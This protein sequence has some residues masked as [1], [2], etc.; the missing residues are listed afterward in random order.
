MKWTFEEARV[1]LAVIILSDRQD[2]WYLIKHWNYWTVKWVNLD[3][4]GRGWMV[5]IR[6]HEIWIPYD[7]KIKTGGHK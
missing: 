5:H 6:G 7:R 4:L 1:K 3:E 2:F